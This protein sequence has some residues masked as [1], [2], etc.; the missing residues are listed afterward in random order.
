M[1]DDRII[2]NYGMEMTEKKGG[3]NVSQQAFCPSSSLA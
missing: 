2:V 3:V 1:P